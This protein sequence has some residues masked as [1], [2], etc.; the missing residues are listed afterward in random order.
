[1]RV[2]AACVTGIPRPPMFALPEAAK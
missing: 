1:L 2:D